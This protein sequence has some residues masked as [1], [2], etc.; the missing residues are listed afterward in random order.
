MRP[1]TERFAVPDR[2]VP[3][4]SEVLRGHPPTHP[5]KGRPWGR[6]KR[7]ASGSDVDVTASGGRPVPLASVPVGFGM[8]SVH[9]T[10]RSFGDDPLPRVWPPPWRALLAGAIFIVAI[11]A[12]AQGAWGI[13]VVALV[14]VALLVIL[15]L[16]HD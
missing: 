16:R 7:G 4:L 6:L 1:G 10:R 2:R 12:V 9:N 11:N 8:A 15:S 13:S 5:H 14:V 3:P